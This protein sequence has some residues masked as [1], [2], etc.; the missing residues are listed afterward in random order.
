MST[1]KEGRSF[2]R[3][4]C[5]CHGE[6]RLCFMSPRYLQPATPAP[7]MPTRPQGCRTPWPCIPLGT[8]NKVAPSGEGQ[9]ARLP[10]EQGAKRLCPRDGRGVGFWLSP[11]G[12]GQPERQRAA[13]A[14]AWIPLSPK[15]P[16]TIV[17]GDLSLPDQNFRLSFRQE[18]LG[19]RRSLPFL[20]RPLSIPFAG[21]KTWQRPGRCTLPSHFYPHPLARG[22]RNGF[23]KVACPIV[24]SI[25][26]LHKERN[27]VSMEHALSVIQFLSAPLWKGASRSGGP[28]PGPVSF[29]T[30]IPPGRDD[31]RHRPPHLPDLLPPALSAAGGLPLG[32]GTAL[33]FCPHAPLVG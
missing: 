32:K 25:L 33:P 29:S 24:I 31:S 8:G 23:A 27:R 3:P 12:S 9:R 28:D 4:S 22:R 30:H 5:P 11:A 7:D 2:L 17:W 14:A 6:T 1:T 10:L 16:P 19:Q 21:R 20:S 18:G 15:G 26:P 13:T